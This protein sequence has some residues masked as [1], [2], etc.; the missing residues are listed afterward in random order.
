M[1]GM[2]GLLGVAEIIIRR[3]FPPDH[4]EHQEVVPED[5]ALIRLNWDS[6]GFIG[7]IMKKK[8]QIHVHVHESMW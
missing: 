5:V 8:S 2:D 4:Y 6:L 1:Q 3:S 7:L